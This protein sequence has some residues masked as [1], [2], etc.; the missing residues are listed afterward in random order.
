M[1]GE[2]QRIVYPER[3]EY[4]SDEPVFRG[5]RIF[6]D[7]W[8]DITA[9]LQESYE[10]LRTRR[11]SKGLLIFGKQG[12]GKSV[13]ANK[14]TGDFELTKS[15]HR[16]SRLTYDKDNIWHRICGG[17]NEKRHLE[18]IAE[19]TSATVVLQ[20]ENNKQ[21]VAEA[22]KLVAGNPDRACLVIADNCE[23]DYFLKGLL[24]VSDDVYLQHG[25]SAAALRAAGHRFVELCRTSLRG[26]FFIFFT[27]DEDFALAF[28][29]HVN[30]QHKGL[31]DIRDLKM[32][33]DIQ[34]EAIVRIN[35]NRLNPF[36]YW[37]CVDRAGPEEKTAVWKT[38]RSAETFPAS[39]QAVDNAIRSSAK[40]R[41]GRPAR[42]CVLNAIALIGSASVEN[43]LEADAAVGEFDEIFVGRNFRIRLYRSDWNEIFGTAREYRMLASEWC[44]KVIVV[45]ESAVAAL[46]AGQDLA[47]QLIDQATTYH[48]PGTH[49]STKEAYANLL[50][51]LDAA[52][53]AAFPTPDNAA[54]WS[55]GGVRN[56]DYE[57]KLKVFFPSYNTKSGGLMSAR[58][59]LVIDDYTPCSVLSAPMPEADAINGAVRR[60]ANIVE[61]TAIKDFAFVR[62]VSYLR[63]Q[64]LGNYIAATQEQ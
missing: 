35:V 28:D 14:I 5:Y 15:S 29:N 21:W 62:L 56:H 40:N 8:N 61:F 60:A 7:H 49:N 50:A 3:A 59:D 31:I 38:L 4:L 6:L 9:Y 26:C 51:Q 12:C 11:F 33:N 22:E 16:E 25:R 10:V 20:V 19:S 27:N 18:N 2:Y 52:I 41:E 23:K 55:K 57:G 63:E 44:L 48:G 43:S 36:S 13:L 32:P 54:F 30:E 64:K 1:A 24:N 53:S 45:G 58:P 39:F 37:L 46:L 42:K 47:K 34:K 17:G